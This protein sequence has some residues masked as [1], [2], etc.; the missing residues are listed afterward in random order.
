M[1]ET[2]GLHILN[3]HASVDLEC[4]LVTGISTESLILFICV[5]SIFPHMQH[6]ALVLSRQYLTHAR[7]FQYIA[8]KVC[9][10]LNIFISIL[11]F[12]AYITAVL[13]PS[14]YLRLEVIQHKHIT[15]ERFI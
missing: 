10:T 12:G 11:T 9:E 8:G 13:G 1:I 3:R 4:M 6:V 15:F 14:I 5:I 2:N 7:C